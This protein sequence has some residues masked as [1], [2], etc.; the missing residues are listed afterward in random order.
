MY[1]AEDNEVMKYIF[2]ITVSGSTT[3]EPRPTIIN[4]FCLSFIPKFNTQKNKFVG[5]S[6]LLFCL[7]SMNNN[8]YERSQ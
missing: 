5:T 7:R 2:P 4:I 1:L 3:N 6:S 8:L